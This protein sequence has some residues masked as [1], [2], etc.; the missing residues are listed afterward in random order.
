MPR[1]QSS[2]PCAPFFPAAAPGWTRARIAPHLDARLRFARLAFDSPAGP[3]ELGW[4]IGGDGAVSLSLRV[5]KG[6]QADV[7]L[8]EHPQALRTTVGAGEYVWHWQPARDLLHPFSVGSIAGDLLG[9][10]EATALL[11]TRVPA[12]YGLIADAGSEFR[13][14]PLADV[15]HT[16]PFL[17]PKAVMALDPALRR[18][19]I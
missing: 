6:A 18:I 3:W 11:R 13:V 5:P 8:P 16:M 2:R 10:E 19:H 7:A 15:S 12:L 9:N 1:T 17:D 14:M 4:E